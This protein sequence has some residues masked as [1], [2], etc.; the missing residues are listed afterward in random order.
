MGLKSRVRHLLGGRPT[1]ETLAG[2]SEQLRALHDKVAQLDGE[3]QALR[4][5]VRAA[6]DDLGDRIGSIAERLNSQA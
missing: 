5:Q 6:V 2:Y 1:N 4:A 3:L